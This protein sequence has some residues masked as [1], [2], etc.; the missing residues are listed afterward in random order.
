M[1]ALFRIPAGCLICLP[2]LLYATLAA[3]NDRDTRGFGITPYI[4]AQ[5]LDKKVAIGGAISGELHSEGGY[6]FLLPESIK[7]TGF[8]SIGLQMGRWGVSAE[9]LFLGD[10][11][12]LGPG[13]L[14]SNTDVGGIIAE[15]AISYQ[16]PR[17]KGIEL[18]A[19]GRFFSIR[20]DIELPLSVEHAGNK[21]WAD[22]FV[23][24]RL[25]YDLSERWYAGMR[26]DIGGFGVSSGQMYNVS[27]YVGYRLNE[28]TTL[29]FGYRHLS[30]ESEENLY[31]YDVS[32]EGLGMG[33]GIRF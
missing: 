22:P 11:D 1:L 4:W 26:A 13:P 8:L 31:R 27:A 20:S 12:G 28:L 29:N 19:G 6:G 24:A 18:L 15:G 9:R 2:L 33:L 16:I 10:T 21:A 14:S 23:G 7:K 5:G 32:L 25:K 30:T 3:G 17:Y